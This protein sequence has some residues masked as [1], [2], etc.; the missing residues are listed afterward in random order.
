MVAANEDSKAAVELTEKIIAGWSKAQPQTKSGLGK[1]LPAVLA[2]YY[3]IMYFIDKEYDDDSVTPVTCDGDLVGEPV[4]GATPQDCA[5]ACDNFVGECV[6]F[7]VLAAEHDGDAGFVCYL[8]SSFTSAQYYTGC[9]APSKKGENFLQ[10]QA[11]KHGSIGGFK[12]RT[13]HEHHTNFTAAQNASCAK[14]RT[15]SSCA[16]AREATVAGMDIPA[17]TDKC[18]LKE[19]NLW[20]H[21]QLPAYFDCLVQCCEDYDPTRMLDGITC[22][23]IEGYGFGCGDI[24]PGHF[25]DGTVVGHICPHHCDSCAAQDPPP[26]TTTTTTPPPPPAMPPTQAPVVIVT[27][28]KAPLDKPVQAM[29]RAKFSEFGG[30]NLKPDPAGKNKFALKELTKAARCSY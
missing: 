16:A 2:Q 13:W 25:P 27:A 24:V 6:G 26:A 14:M 3:S 28:K 4:L 5:A 18:Y 19:N 23:D 21:A 22:D 17:P 9:D 8:F 7:M 15:S 30:V 11:A 12:T 10:V 29:C 1:F 20:T